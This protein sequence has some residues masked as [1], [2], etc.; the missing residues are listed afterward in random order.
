[1]PRLN[2]TADNLKSLR[3]SLF[4]LLV[5]SRLIPLPAACNGR[6]KPDCYCIELDEGRNHDWDPSLTFHLPSTFGASQPSDVNHTHDHFLYK[7]KVGSPP[8][9]TNCNLQ[10]NKKQISYRFDSASPVSFCVCSRQCLLW[11]AWAP[12]LPP[13]VADK[14]GAEE[15]DLYLL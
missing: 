5:S 4:L 9:A 2:C 1:M 15:G 7:P 10:T 6:H 13:R 8:Q 11:P 3:C 14:Y 12:A